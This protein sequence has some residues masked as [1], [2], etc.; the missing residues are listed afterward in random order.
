MTEASFG[1]FPWW[2]RSW[3]GYVPWLCHH[4]CSL[5]CVFCHSCCCHPPLLVF[6]S[7]ATTNKLEARQMRLIAFRVYSTR[8]KFT[9]QT[10]ISIGKKLH[11]ATGKSSH[12]PSAAITMGFRWSVNTTSVL[13]PRLFC[14]SRFNLEV[15]NAH[16][17]SCL[18]RAYSMLCREIT[19][20]GRELLGSNIRNWF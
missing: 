11:S 18:T 10:K 12:G 16:L 4:F 6:I 19:S 7:M 9:S 20:V 2:F 8:N 5:A 15:D 3:W 13:V 1:S 17:S 14:F